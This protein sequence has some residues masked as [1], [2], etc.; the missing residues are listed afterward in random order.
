MKVYPIFLNN[1]AGK[2]C[3]IFGGNHE[4]ERKAAGL[5]ACDAAITVYSEHVTHKLRAWSEQG[6]MKWVPRWYAVGDLEDAFLAIVAITDHEATKPIWVEA[7]REK[8]LINAMDDVPHCTFVA[9]SV[10]EQGPLTI[11]ISTSGCAP[12]LSVRLR[13][14]LEQRFSP[15]YGQFLRVMRTLRPLMA[16]T[17]ET[18]D[19][20]RKHWYALVDS[21]VLTLL[22]RGDE[23]GACQE[24]KSILGFQE[25]ICM[26]QDGSCACTQ[27]APDAST[28]CSDKS[29]EL[30]N[31]NAV[32]ASF[33]G[34]NAG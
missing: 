32:I 28:F 6:K 12:A 18:F 25:G 24:I 7:E 10:I 21:N 14:E 1:L 33:A 22:E 23:S 4:A 13:E 8:V 27:V 19:E 9:G 3:V 17:F 16:Q 31:S 20:R 34:F 5:L 2:R 29:S 15:A 11:S 30:A 26:R